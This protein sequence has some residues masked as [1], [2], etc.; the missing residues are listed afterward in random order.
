VQPARGTLP[1]V[2]AL[3]ALGLAFDSAAQAVYY[4]WI[5][6]DGKVQFADKP[7]VNFKGE[8]T[9]VMIDTPADPP[10][11]A[12]PAPRAPAKARAA[13]EDEKTPDL[14][15]R[16]RQQREALEA[17]VRQARLNL[18]AAKKA[19]SEGEGT[20]DDERQFV[21]QN[22]AR[23]EKNPAKTPPPRGN[24]MADRAST[25]QAIWNCPRSIPKEAYFDR[26]QKLD[27]A[28]KK[29]EEELAEAERAYRRGVD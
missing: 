25:G 19:L 12:A 10:P 3:F 7:P 11:K 20:T 1:F 26:Q 17:R 24:C 14:N 15:T 4:R 22:F 21:R 23:D 9:K 16:R 6:K 18:E 28:V 5:D 8:V 13:D 27:D 29:A 2:A